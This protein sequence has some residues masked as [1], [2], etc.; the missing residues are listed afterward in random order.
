[1]FYDVTTCVLG[2]ADQP[3]LGPLGLPGS[4]RVRVVTAP[5]DVVGRAGV[6]AARP[7]SVPGP[8]QAV[9]LG[10]RPPAEVRVEV[11]LDRGRCWR[12]RVFI[13]IVLFFSLCFL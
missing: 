13:C 4:F 8:V 11:A 1:M 2:G 7:R 3:G 5:G 9:V 10:L 6:N 12:T